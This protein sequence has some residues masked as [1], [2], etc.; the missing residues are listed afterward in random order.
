[1]NTKGGKF[2][3]SVKRTKKDDRIEYKRENTPNII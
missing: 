1:M 2:I 3:G